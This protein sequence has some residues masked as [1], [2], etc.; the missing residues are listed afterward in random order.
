MR[1]SPYQPCWGCGLLAGGNESHLY[2]GNF[3]FGIE[4][5]DCGNRIKLLLDRSLRALSTLDCDSDGIT[6]EIVKRA[7]ITT[8]ARK[9]EN[10]TLNDIQDDHTIRSAVET[11]GMEAACAAFRAISTLDNNTWETRLKVHNAI[12][13]GPALTAEELS[14]EDKAKLYGLLKRGLECKKHREGKRL[15]ALERMDQQL[16]QFSEAIQ[17]QQNK[18]PYCILTD[19]VRPY[20]RNSEET[21]CLQKLLKEI[22]AKGVWRILFLA[23]ESQDPTYTYITH[24]FVEHIALL[25]G[26]S[27]PIE[28]QEAWQKTCGYQKKSKAIVLPLDCLEWKGHWVLMSEIGMRLSLGAGSKE[29]PTLLSV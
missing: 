9:L 17:S 8:S 27:S 5:M 20:Y 25:P 12:M 1:S 3:P 2:Y 21:K 29:R 28:A 14:N 6:Q 15:A 24:L 16:Q 22:E 23:K 10:R 11:E 7:L 18:T 19:V 26:G 4:H 13:L